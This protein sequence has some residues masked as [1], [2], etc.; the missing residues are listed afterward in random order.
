MATSTDDRGD[1]GGAR[2]CRRS[3]QTARGEEW[4]R[5]QPRALRCSGGAATSRSVLR[6]RVC[7][8]EG[9]VRVR[10]DGGAADGVAAAC[11]E[12]RL[13]CRGKRGWG[14]KAHA[15]TV[16]D[17]GGG[18]AATISDGGAGQDAT[19]SILEAAM[20]GSVRRSA[21]VPAR[22]LWGIGSRGAWR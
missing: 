3:P 1:G 12:R 15:A 22:R 4:C 14:R 5:R 20:R 10:K 16:L 19:R 9:G 17:G 6:R 21:G 8:W 13:A 7:G 11:G 2:R 18:Q